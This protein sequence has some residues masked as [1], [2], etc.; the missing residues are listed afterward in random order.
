MARL[1]RWKA[2]KIALSDVELLSMQQRFIVSD[3]FLD[4]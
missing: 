3:F 4:N 1:L 2:E